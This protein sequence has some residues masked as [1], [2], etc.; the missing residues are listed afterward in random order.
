MSDFS[1]GHDLVVCGFGPRAWSQLRILCLPLSLP[2][3]WSGSV[4]LFLKNKHQKIIIISNSYKH[5]SHRS[6]GLHHIIKQRHHSQLP[7]FT[8]IW[9]NALCPQQDL[10]TSETHTVRNMCQMIYVFPWYQDS[11]TVSSGLTHQWELQ[12]L[13]LVHLLRYEYCPLLNVLK[14]KLWRQ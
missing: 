5:V 3:P 11:L 2:I 10:C 9:L 14:A 6:P 4:S 8:N 1:L 12:A 7:L 13:V